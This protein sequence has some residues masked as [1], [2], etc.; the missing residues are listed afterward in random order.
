MVKW[1]AGD[2]CPGKFTSADE[3]VKGIVRRAIKYVS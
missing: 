3:E 1:E 2:L